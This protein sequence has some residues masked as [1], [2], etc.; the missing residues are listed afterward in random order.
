MDEHIHVTLDEV[1]DLYKTGDIVQVQSGSGFSKKTF[2]YIKQTDGRWRKVIP[3]QMQGAWSWGV[4]PT[5]EP[6]PS[7]PEGEV[8]FFAST[9]S[10]KKIIEPIGMEALV[11]GVRIK[12]RTG[13]YTMHK[14]RDLRTE[15]ETKTVMGPIPKG[16]KL[17]MYAFDAEVRQGAVS[18]I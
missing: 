10:G 5:G 6:L 1:R 12:G 9:W 15:Q 2:Q 13:T 11:A 3:T 16:S 8:S 14:D 17:P 18:L 7:L 4:G